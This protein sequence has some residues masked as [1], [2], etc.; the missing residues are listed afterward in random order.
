MA[1]KTVGTLTAKLKT[2]SADFKKGMRGA[3]V[4]VESIKAAIKLAGAALKAF[5]KFMKES[6]A[7]AGFQ[8]EAMVAL[9]SALARAGV[10]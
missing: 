4:Q 7:L 8:Q 5:G 6:A 10:T 1:T 3:L 9:E 2:D